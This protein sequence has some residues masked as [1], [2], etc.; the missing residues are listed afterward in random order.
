M[1][2][3]ADR[4]RINSLIPGIRERQVNAARAE[5][6]SADA[7]ATASR[8]TAERAVAHKAQVQTLCR[9]FASWASS[10]GMRPNT[11]ELTDFAR[12][13]RWRS[14]DADRSRWKV[15]HKSGWAL[16][17][18]EYPYPDGDGADHAS[19]LV[20]L[21][22]EIVTVL[23]RSGGRFKGSLPTRSAREESYAHLQ[24]QLLDFSISSIEQSI[25][26]IAAANDKYLD[27]AF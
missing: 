9:R 10:A 16:G 2:G 4:D 3:Y 24:K 18:H 12:P 23:F 7:A 6:R 17:H 8:I 21:D 19:L 27:D 14:R 22:G 15:V 26:E 1:P 25:A 5:R 20:G 11:F 13:N